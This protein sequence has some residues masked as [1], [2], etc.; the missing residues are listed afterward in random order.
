MSSCSNFVDTK[1]NMVNDKNEASLKPHRP[2]HVN[3]LSSIKQDRDYIDF[4]IAQSK[5]SGQY[6]LTDLND[7]QRQN[8]I[9]SAT[10]NPR[11]NFKDGIVTTIDYLGRDNFTGAPKNIITTTPTV[12]TNKQTVFAYETNLYMGAKTTDEDY[13]NLLIPINKEQKIKT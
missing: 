3:D 2:F 1:I 12:S 4:E 9:E 8:L 7:N 13:N 11:I 10:E 5:G 6:V